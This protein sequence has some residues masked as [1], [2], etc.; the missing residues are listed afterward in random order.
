[1]NRNRQDAARARY[2]FLTAVLGVLC[3]SALSTSRSSSF[4]LYRIPD[5]SGKW[6]R[7]SDQKPPAGVEAQE[8][9]DYERVSRPVT[10]NA[11]DRHILVYVPKGD[12]PKGVQV[13]SDVWYAIRLAEQIAGVDLPIP[14]DIKV[15][16]VQA[17]EIGAAAD[18]HGSDG[19]MASEHDPYLLYHEIAH[20]WGDFEVFTERWQVEGFA[21]LVAYVVGERLTGRRR[22][23][24]FRAFRFQR[25]REYLREPGARDF[26]LE[27]WKRGDES[28]PGR[29]AFA[30]GKSLAAWCLMLDRVGLRRL[31]EVNRTIRERRKP[32]NTREFL[33]LLAGDDDPRALDA[34]L[35]GWVFDDPY[36][37]SGRPVSLNTYLTWLE[38]HP[39][40]VPAQLD[41]RPATRG[42]SVRGI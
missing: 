29:E 31:Q 6:F 8:V 11:G 32:V 15:Y 9:S 23:E 27:D 17:E 35:G 24:M 10:L 25:L 7:Y 19:I 36:L 22:A 5:A 12:R 21:D 1:M 28:T 20:F 33:A 3:V 2:G 16:C 13:A 39:P 34:L 18:F 38:A 14:G 42:A 37:L 26:P 40:S 4:T 30:Y 41:F